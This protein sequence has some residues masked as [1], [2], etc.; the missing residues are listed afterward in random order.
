MIEKVVKQFAREVADEFPELREILDEAKAG[1]ITEGDALR[2]LS[3]VLANNPGLAQRFQKKA[4]EALEPVAGESAQPLEH[5]GLVMHPERG[6]PK[7]NPLVEA[8]LIERAQFD[9]DMPE[10][11]TGPQPT[12]VSPA[13]SVDTDA[14]SPEVLGQMLTQASEKVAEDVARADEDRKMLVKQVVGGDEEGLLAL[15]E[16]AGVMDPREAAELVLEGK[17]DLVDPASYRRGQLPPP[18]VVR[19]P[20]GSA[21]LAL[22]PEERRQSAWKFLSTTQGRRSAVRAIAELVQ[23]KLLGEGIDVSVRDFQ[24][25]PDGVVLAAH[26][27]T[28]RIDGPG[29]TQSSFSLMDIAAA[30]IAKNLAEKAGGWRGGAELE[31]AA[32][33]TVDVRAVGWAGRLIVGKAPELP[34]E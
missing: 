34:S 8:A 26:E 21:L 20:S 16:Q 19:K 22:S 13:V 10:L 31:V 33:N 30:S 24:P 6:A 18:V 28:A 7:L 27:W 4:L 32:V 12:G 14:R 15:M 17:S 11:R 25:E 1:V 2:S 23:V 3:E 5:G 9:G 29:S